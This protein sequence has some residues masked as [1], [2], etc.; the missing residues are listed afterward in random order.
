M[1]KGSDTFEHSSQDNVQPVTSGGVMKKGADVLAASELG[2]KKLTNQTKKSEL[3]DDADIKKIANFISEHREKVDYTK[4]WD[5]KTPVLF[6]GERHTVLSDKDELIRQIPNF[7]KMGMTHIAIEMLREEEQP[8]ID[9]YFK[10][11]IEREKILAIFKNGWDKGEGIPEKYMEIIDTAKANG[12]AVL[13]I[14][15][16]TASSEYSTGAFF[17]KRNMNWARIIKETI[18]KQPKA[19]VLVYNGSAHSGYNEVDDSAN[20]ILKKMSIVAKVVEFAGG[21]KVE[22]EPY[23]FDDKI[24]VAAKLQKLADSRFA[25]KID[26]KDEVRGTD[27]I[28]HLP[29][30]EKAKLY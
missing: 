27:Y 24:G 22:G 5:K 30:V 16:Y 4:L 6:I 8:L 10:G 20:E 13:C 9:G 3:S 29:Q 17:K 7:K 21:E 26:S 23:L 1:T 19:R 2:I 14:D 11:I 25:L 28:V 12:I 15:L 18:K